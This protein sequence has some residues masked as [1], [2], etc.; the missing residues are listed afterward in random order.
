[1]E[2]KFF[3]VGHHHQNVVKVVFTSGAMRSKRSKTNLSKAKWSNANVVDYVS[4]EK[5]Q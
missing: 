1:V 3:Q 4:D 5:R 2:T